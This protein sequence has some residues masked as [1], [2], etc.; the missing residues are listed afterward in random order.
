MTTRSISDNLARFT[1]AYLPDR[2]ELALS[3]D[4][5]QLDR[6]LARLAQEN[7]TKHFITQNYEGD[8]DVVALRCA[9]DAKHAVQ[10]IFAAPGAKKFSDTPLLAASPG[11]RKVLRTF[12]CPLRS[13]RLARL[14]PGSLL[15]EHTD[16]D[17]GF[18]AG[19]VRLHVP[20]VTN[21]DVVFLING[22]R[23]MME[24]GSVWYLRLSDPHSVANRGVTDRIHML[25][26]AELNDWL[27]ALIAQASGLES[28]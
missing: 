23:V 5:T 18:E 14:T 17:F 16:H 15:K 11:F 21:P 6:D 3:F 2:L 12:R 4:V 22:T 1:S 13:V 20:I 28:G 27:R 9:S 19:T 7:W 10:Q 8:W 25:I 24:A 26:D